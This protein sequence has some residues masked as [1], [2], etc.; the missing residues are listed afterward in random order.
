MHIEIYADIHENNKAHV[1]SGMVDMG[2]SY[3]GCIDEFCNIVLVIH[4]FGSALK[5]DRK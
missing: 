3:F 4:C 5:Y 1:V 2:E